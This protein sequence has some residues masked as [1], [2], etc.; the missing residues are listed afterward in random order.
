MIDGVS[1][2]FLGMPGIDVWLFAGLSFA[3]LVTAFIAAVAGTAGGLILIA[4][5]AFVFPPALLIPLH[6]VIQLGV[7]SSMLLSR[8]RYFMRDTLAPFIIGTAVGAAIGGR[9]FV[10]LPES[11]LLIILGVSMLILTW[12]P[13]IARFG[14][15]RGRFVFV[16]FITTF[17]GIFISATGSLLAAFTAAAA[18]DRRNHIATLGGLMS[19]VHIAKLVA[20]GI[21]GVEFGSYAPLVAAMILTSWIGIFLGR[22]VLDRIPERL[23]RITF[24]IILTLLSLRLIAKAVGWP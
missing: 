24:Q 22:P 10:N 9:I 5:M 12:I 21:L 23:F 3:A 19:I 14:P 20:F 13:A 18:P 1:E 8:W 4:I 2:Q 7:S 6:T 17:L 16:G 11:I 15:E